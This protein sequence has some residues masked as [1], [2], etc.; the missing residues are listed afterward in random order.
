MDANKAISLWLVYIK[1]DI[2]QDLIK[3]NQSLVAYVYN[4]PKG[5]E[6]ISWI[7]LLKPFIKLREISEEKI[8][9][10]FKVFRPDL[11]K[12]LNNNKG[13]LHQQIVLCK[14]EI[15]KL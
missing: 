5:R 9:Q 12:L 8:L 4:H 13:W 7:K 10:Q 11:Y 6:V 2:L 15:E 14:R 1:Y 3:N